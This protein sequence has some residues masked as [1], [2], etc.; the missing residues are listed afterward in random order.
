MK[1]ITIFMLVVAVSI[2]CLG[3]T[4]LDVEGRCG[5]GYFGIHPSGDTSSS[6]FIMSVGADTYCYEKG[7]LELGFNT[8]F[9]FG[10]GSQT[11]K[12]SSSTT[13]VGSTTYT[14]TTA[15][16]SS[17]CF[18]ST[19]FFGPVI[20][21]NFDDKISGR[22]A[23]GYEGLIEFSTMAFE[24]SIDCS[25]NEKWSCGLEF[26]YGVAVNVIDFNLNAIYKF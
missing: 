11:T 26:K 6:M 9:M 17:T 19:F 10:V 12:A 14:S 1:K 3:A 4:D 8:Q 15:A 22:I 21:Y 23:L 5:I 7:G 18:C 2:F 25:I 20:K 24:F 13:K 16:S